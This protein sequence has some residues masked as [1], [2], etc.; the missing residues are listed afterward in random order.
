MQ[1]R[2]CYSPFFS[3]TAANYFPY[4]FTTI[5]ALLTSL[6]KN[7]CNGPSSLR[8]PSYTPNTFMLLSCQPL[9]N[10]YR[11]CLVLSRAYS[12]KFSLCMFDHF[13]F[14]W[15]FPEVLF[16]LRYGYFHF[17]VTIELYLFFFTSLIYCNSHFVVTSCGLLR[18]WYLFHHCFCPSCTKDSPLLQI[19]KDVVH[20]RRLRWDEELLI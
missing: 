3:L 17:I 14:Y 18:L 1:K 10:W 15:W 7:P 13:K 20:S 16:Y 5:A 11:D 6:S 4:V 8:D 12:F 19:N 2:S 9:P